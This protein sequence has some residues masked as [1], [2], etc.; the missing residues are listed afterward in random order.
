V[1]REQRVGYAPVAQLDRASAFGAEGWGF[2]SLQAHLIKMY[3]VY[4]LRSLKT[5]K[6][7]VGS[8]TLL[9][10]IRTKE[11]NTGKVPWTRSHRPLALVYSEQF[12]SGDIALKR[13]RFFKTGKGRVVLESLLQN[14]K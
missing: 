4:V 8:T 10:E 2:K 11:H 7:Y 5:G 14:K 13:E 6:R 3:Y 9:P 12:E 1:A